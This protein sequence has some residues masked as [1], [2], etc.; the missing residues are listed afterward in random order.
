MIHKLKFDTG[1]SL[2]V[3]P[4]CFG[5]TYVPPPSFVDSLLGTKC[6]IEGDVPVIE[7]ELDKYAKFTDV[8][9][10]PVS[11]IG[12]IGQGK[13][14]CSNRFINLLLEEFYDVRYQVFPCYVSNE[15]SRKA[16]NLISL[17]SY[18]DL[19]IDYPQSKLSTRVYIKG[20]RKESIIKNVNSFDDLENLSIKKVFAKEI[21]FKR[22]AEPAGI[23]I[24]RDI[25]THEMFCTDEFWEKYTKLKLT[26]LKLVA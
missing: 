14:I 7:F 12:G 16:Y 19:E 10:G 2:G 22:D 5:S 6:L 8:I 4:Q 26:G 18:G 23:F 15:H 25:F 1:G 11:L 3:F 9:S 17:Y 21:I 24:L 13:F 20:K